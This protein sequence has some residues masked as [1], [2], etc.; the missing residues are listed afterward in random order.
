MSYKAD[1]RSEKARLK[2]TRGCYVLLLVL[3][4]L[5]VPGCSFSRLQVTEVSKQFLK[6]AEHVPGFLGAATA[7]PLPE[8]PVNPEQ[9]TANEIFNII[10]LPSVAQIEYFAGGKVYLA[11]V[12][13]EKGCALIGETLISLGKK[14]S[15]CTRCDEVDYKNDWSM[16]WII[17]TAVLVAVLAVIAVI[18]YIVAYRNSRRRYW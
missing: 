10:D 2:Q 17:P 13:A 9:E 12:V 5:L 14:S 7:A 3:L 15:T 1:K 18:R 11:E 16:I 4:L 6:T 8:Q